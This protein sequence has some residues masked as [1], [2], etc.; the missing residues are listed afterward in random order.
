M[1]FIGKFVESLVESLNKSDIE[2]FEVAC[3]EF[4]QITPLDQW[5]TSLLLTAKSH[6]ASGDGEEEPDLS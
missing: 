4:D 5:K 2:G 1:G 3:A 6:I